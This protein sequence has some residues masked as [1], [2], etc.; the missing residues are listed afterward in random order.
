MPETVGVPFHW[1]ALVCG[2]MASAI[3]YLIA[4]N[5]ADSSARLASESTH[6]SELLAVSKEMVAQSAA[7]STKLTELSLKVDELLRGR[8]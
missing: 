6:R 4:W 1:V 3:A 7:L 5:R 8:P 2:A